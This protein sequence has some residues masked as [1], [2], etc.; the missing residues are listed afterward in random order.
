MRHINK[1]K[2]LSLYV[3]LGLIWCNVGFAEE[4]DCNTL[5][6]CLN[7][8][9]IIKS[10]MTF[11]PHDTIFNIIYELV[12]KRDKVLIHCIVK[13]RLSSGTTRLKGSRC[14]KP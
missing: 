12:K 3:F 13:Y 14:Y 8:N 4:A 2:K 10:K 11:K 9:Y 1:M 6:E 7:K 5:N